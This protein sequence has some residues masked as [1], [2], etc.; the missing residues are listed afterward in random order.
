MN[1]TDNINYIAD[2]GKVF[3]RNSDNVIVGWGIGIGDKDDINNYTE[4]ECPQEFKGDGRYDNT[5]EEEEPAPREE[6]V[7][8]QNMFMLKR[9]INN[10]TEN[11]NE[12]LKQRLIDVY[13]QL[14]QKMQESNNQQQTTNNN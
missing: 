12:T 6:V 3:I 8:K 2:E 11:M 1:T 14:M 10:T 13:N 9:Q 7:L 4:I 5:I